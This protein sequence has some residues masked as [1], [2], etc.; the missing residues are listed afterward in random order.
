M[1]PILRPGHNVWRDDAVEVA[2]LLVD[3]DDYYRAFYESAQ[4]ARNYIL[5]AGWQFDSDACLLRGP[6]AE[7]AELPVTLLKFLNAL[8]ERTKE[9]RI[10]MLAW[11]FH[12]VFALEREWMQELVFNWRTSDR[13]T[14]RFDD[15]TVENGSHHQKFVVIDG[16]ISYLGGLDLCDHRWDTR[17]HKDPDPLRVS[18]GEP[19][20][21]FHDVQAFL[22]GA[23]V[24]RDL[25]KLFAARW[26][27]SGADAFEL[28]GPRRDFPKYSPKGAVPIDA[29]R[30]ALSRTDPHGLPAPGG[31]CKEVAALHRDAIAAAERV[32]YIETQYFSSKEI[33]AALLDRLGVAGP[34]LELAIVLNL[35]A[36]TIKEEVAVG[37]AQAR[38]LGE[39]RRAVTGTPHHLGIY[40][41]LPH[42]EGEGTPERATYIHSKVMVV[43]DRFLTVGSANLTNRSMGVDTELNASFEAEDPRSPLAQS[44]ARA[45][46]SLIEEH[47]GAALDT[48]NG[49][50]L[51][52]FL[53]ERAASAQGRLRI[54]PSPTE[55]EKTLLEVIDPD[56][57][58]FDPAAIEDSDEDR[59][60][61][62]SGLGPLWARLSG[63]KA[64]KPEP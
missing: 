41:T 56:K 17:S 53:N 63:A 64:P 40:Y 60:I 12:A 38:I 46:V 23:D 57:L 18:R 31:E 14:F 6:E 58:P 4:L 30:V 9:L 37:L 19:H 3:G 42:H 32:I 49:Q 25:T 50:C 10:Y 15:S 44:I 7:G 34:P 47:L 21:P 61:F 54:H 1:R 22:A 55:R 45:R 13:L 35:A 20:K 16:A 48:A 11:D 39:L 26:E 51:V 29:T 52:D 24:A 2:A 8:C 33:T 59:S 28:P 43:D 27:A 62:A 5:L 36:E